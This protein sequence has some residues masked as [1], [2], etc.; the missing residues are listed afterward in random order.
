MMDLGFE[1]R[2]SKISIN[3]LTFFYDFKDTNTSRKELDL[4]EKRQCL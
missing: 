4:Y 1:P 3:D 2:Y